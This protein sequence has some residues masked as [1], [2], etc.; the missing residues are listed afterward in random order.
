MERPSAEMALQHKYFD[1]DPLPAKPGTKE[2]PKIMQLSR[3][4]NIA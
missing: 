2:Y 3:I 1:I 4:S